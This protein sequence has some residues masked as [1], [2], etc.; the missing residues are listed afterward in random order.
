M[1]SNIK[2]EILSRM[3]KNIKLRR[4]ELNITQEELGIACGYKPDSAKGAISRIESGQTDIQQTRLFL[5]AKRLNISPCD[6]MD[7]NSYNDSYEG[8][9]NDDISHIL[10]ARS[11]KLK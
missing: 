7:W 8:G 11:G 2:T 3:G 9:Q 10:A 6:L 4:E 5:I 1:D